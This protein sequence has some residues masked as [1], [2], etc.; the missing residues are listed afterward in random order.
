[1]L[2]VAIIDV[3]LVGRKKH[4]FPNLVCMK[5]SGYHKEIGDDVVFKTDYKDL[6]CFD[7]VYLSKVFTDTECPE[8]VLKLPNVTY[9]GTGFFY[10]KAPPLPPEIEH[11]MPDYHLYDEWVQARLDA[12][13]KPRELAYYTDY[14]I[15][16]LTRGCF[17]KC[18]FCVNKNYDRVQVH[19]PLKEFYDPT[20]PKICLQDDNFLGCSAW[21]EMLDELKATGRPFQFR[22]GLDERILTEEKC[23]AL[24]SSKYD[25]DFIFAFDNLAEAQL[26]ESK[27]KMA[28]KYTNAV[29]KFYCFTGFDR[30][31]KWDA[32][33][34]R[35]DIFDLFV[36]I[37]I[38]MRNKCMPYVTRF[39]RYTD[40]PYRGVY[41]TVA[42][43]C[44]QPSFY[45]KK[46]V[47]EFAEM[48]GNEAAAR[49]LN[50][51]ETLFP[52]IAPYYDM[53]YSEGG[54]SS[55]ENQT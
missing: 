3:D 48:H 54:L 28:R 15:G 2:T 12:G 50:E 4:R 47:R 55:D 23:A 16:F 10:D 32:D 46:S 9:G 37:D 40:S 39:A 33:F 18:A 22:Q 51:F 38:L 27:I 14:S 24:F 11:H 36:R 21:K 7:K 45:K 26:I 19:S 31:D 8:D 5:L 43:W 34:W 17:R 6:E 52:E 44:N 25:G 29:L 1:M 13:A 41:I 35:Q 30:A 42:R 49:Y 20:R 53:K